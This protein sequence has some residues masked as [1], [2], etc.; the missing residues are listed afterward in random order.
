M[1]RVLYLIYESVSFCSSIKERFGVLAYERVFFCH[2]KEHLYHHFLNLLC[3]V[4]VLPFD[5]ELVHESL[6]DDFG[7][8]Y[9][10][11]DDSNG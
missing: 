5:S 6:M 10:D 2:K 8:I 1:N 9:D 4:E 11:D 7:E 3:R